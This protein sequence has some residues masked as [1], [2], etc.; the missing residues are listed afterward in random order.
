MDKEKEYCVMDD[1]DVSLT[2]PINL[3]TE[4]EKEIDDAIDKRLKEVLPHI[5]GQ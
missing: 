5:F 4:Q 3:T 2:S 1:V